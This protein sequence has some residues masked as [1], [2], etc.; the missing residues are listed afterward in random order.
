MLKIFQI[1]LLFFVFTYSLYSANDKPK[2][3]NAVKSLS[4]ITLDGKLSEAEWANAI[5]VSDFIQRDP[6][7]GALG[8]EHTELRILYTNEALYIG[9]RLFDSEPQSII[10]KEMARDFE[11]SRDD[12]LKV[13]LDTYNDK[14]SGYLFIVNPNGAMRDVQII[15]NGQR[16]NA[17]WNGVWDAKTHID[18]LGW[19]VEI[20]IPFSSLK[21]SNANEQ[22]W[23][24]N[25]ERDIRRKRENV[26]W[27]GYSRN[28][29]IE[30][31]SQAGLL[32]GISGV[33]SARN[34]EFKPY[35]VLGLQRSK[36]YDEAQKKMIYDEKNSRDF[37]FD[38]N[39]L[40]TPSVKFNVTY[41]TDFAQV[42]S[43]N[44]D[45]NLT[46]FPLYF[47]EKREFFLEGADY[48]SIG[49]GN[50]I[51]PFYSRR[52]GISKDGALAPII[53]GARSLGQVDNTTFGIMSIQT[54][55]T[56][57]EAESNYTI[58]N[59]RQQLQGQSYIGILSANKSNSDNMHSTS[60]L[61]GKYSTDNFLNSGKNFLWEAA[62][63]HN[64]NSN[65][66]FLP[67]AQAYRTYIG[68]NN[69]DISFGASTQRCPK[70]FNPEAGF[71][72]RSNF[73]EYYAS[74][75]YKYRFS[76]AN[77]IFNTISFSPGDISYD[78]YDD[79]KK[80]QS[81]YYDV[82]LANLTFRS[83]DN[84]AIG[85]SRN[86]EGVLSDFNL[87]I[88]NSDTLKVLAKDYWANSWWASF[89]SY[90][91]R[92]YNLS[93]YAGKGG[94]YDGDGYEYAIS[95]GYRLSKYLKLSVGYRRNN[96]SFSNQDYR[97]I[98]ERLEGRINLSLSP[99]LFGSIY[100]QWNNKKDLLVVNYRINF[101]PNFRRGLLFCS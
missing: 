50:R 71:L 43:D 75:S 78:I 2:I 26:L 32:K 47:A 1:F 57:D 45:V 84:I 24:I 9:A 46:R 41:N 68:F 49:M 19:S 101:I 92:D 44:L 23:G 76:D 95:G 11:N 81:V 5:P 37:G 4:K 74:L 67:D 66:V 54:D 42:E 69:D 13:I 87:D 16:Q 83:N 77:P 59:V 34:I 10:S 3:I 65:Q 94:L 98:S 63:L 55:K 7:N 60:G 18:S 80:M 72:A 53:V 33:N 20:Y 96:Y 86:G 25:F 73:R 22:T 31:V 29:S 70:D 48:F 79:T 27:Q 17:N 88:K 64:F 61:Y 82:T 90:Y 62:Y 89:D 93:L 97:L 91:A 36:S 28:Y 15:E 38:I 21:F 58:L 6:E 56:D 40:P 39:Y 52:I 35:S 51:Y 100:A 30:T 99:K 8:T 85:F 14:S 12:G